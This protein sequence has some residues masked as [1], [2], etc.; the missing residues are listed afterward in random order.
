[1]RRNGKRLLFQIKRVAQIGE[2][3]DSATAADGFQFLVQSTVLGGELIDE[4]SRRTL[5]NGNF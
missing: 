4:L 3:A 2:T 5:H 1:V